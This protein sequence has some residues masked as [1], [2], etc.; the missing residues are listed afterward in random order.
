MDQVSLATL[1]AEVLETI[2]HFLSIFDTARLELVRV[3][4]VWNFEPF[5]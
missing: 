4:L 5:H 3:R 2:C 1:P